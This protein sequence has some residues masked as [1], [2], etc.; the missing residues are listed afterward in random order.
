MRGALKSEKVRTAQDQTQIVLDENVLFSLYAIPLW[1][2]V[3]LAK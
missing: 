3:A 1:L 2:I